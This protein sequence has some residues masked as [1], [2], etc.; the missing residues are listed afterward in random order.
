MVTHDRIRLIGPLRESPAP[1]GLFYG[2]FRWILVWVRVAGMLK[3]ISPESLDAGAQEHPATP[4]LVELQRTTADRCMNPRTVW[5][6]YRCPGA[7]IS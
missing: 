2:C 4:S 1:A 5:L 3:A 7:S 6:E